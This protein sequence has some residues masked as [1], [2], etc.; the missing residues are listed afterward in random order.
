GP[1]SLTMWSSTQIPH[2]LRTQ[3]ALQL[4]LPEI[5]V[6]VIAPEVGGGFG[7]KLNVYRE[8]ILC[9][10]ISMKLGKPVKWTHTRRE[11]LA[12]TTH[13]RGQVE[14]VEVA[15][16]K[17]GEMT[18]LRAKIYADLGAYCQFFTA[19]IAGFTT[20]LMH[21]CYK[22]PAMA[23]EVVAVFTNKMATD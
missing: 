10:A 5:K 9:S 11:D 16:K 3:V 14:Y 1:K 20:I 17:D 19:G 2:L 13:G 6:R 7:A 15:C 23:W 8:E 12:A 22:I 21:G 18:A 4:K